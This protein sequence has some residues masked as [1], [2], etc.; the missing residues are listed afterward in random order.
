M[1]KKYIRKSHFYG[2]DK[3]RTSHHQPKSQAGVLSQLSGQKTPFC[4]WPTTVMGSV[5]A[6][7]M[8]VATSALADTPVLLAKKAPLS[9]ASPT[10]LTKVLPPYLPPFFRD[11]VQ[12]KP[13]L[14][15]HEVLFIDQGVSGYQGLLDSMA[16]DIEV[17]FLSP[18]QDGVAAIAEHL[19][20]KTD[21]RGI[22]IVSHG[23]P[24]RLYL[25]N[26][27]LS[28]EELAQRQHDLS[29]WSKALGLEG[30]V[31]LYGCD[32]ARGV[33]G[34]RF[35]NRLS[36]A[37]T[38]GISASSDP[39]GSSV[40]G[41]DWAFEYSRN[42]ETETIFTGAVSNRFHALL[43]PGKIIAGDG[44]GGGGGGGLGGI[45]GSKY[46]PGGFGGKGG[47]GAG[48]DDTLTGTD[49]ND[50]IFGDGN[51]GGGGGGGAG[52]NAYAGGAGYSGGLGGSGADV[53]NGGGGDDILFG[54]G[55]NGLYGENGTLNTG[56]TGGA[57]G[58]ETLDA[59]SGGEGGAPV[60]FDTVKYSGII[61]PTGTSGKA[62]FGGA[63][64]G[65]PGGSTSNSIYG[66][67]GDNGSTDPVVQDDTW[68]ADHAVTLAKIS[69][70]YYDGALGGN[71]DDEL[72]GGPGSDVLFGMGGANT[73]IFE[74]N[75]A[76]SG[77]DVD[78]I[79][80]WNDGSGN[81]IELRVDGDTFDSDQVDTVV[82]SQGR[83]LSD[84]FVTHKDDYRQ[85]TIVVKNLGRDLTSADF[86]IGSG[87][88]I[89][90][91]FPWPM[92][93]PAIISGGQKE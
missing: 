40:L 12:E 15:T 55:L 35:V 8:V 28:V 25:G 72:D 41:G 69:N 34:I 48:D 38:A 22:H 82:A 23:D 27:T 32:V 50:V 65:L 29:I 70:G 33:E 63:L 78:V 1:V 4:G 81:L 21:L 56:G 68:G 57:S 16:R 52:T 18:D 14:S 54:D 46:L 26:M 7:G 58:F 20:G 74:T 93:M 37:L 86:V 45:Y 90:P 51:G 62:G 76:T 24:G 11:L 10:Y 42:V 43:A 47:D 64:G 88:V 83:A 75:D 61:S 59:G 44:S 60:D 39:T 84:R 49:G 19:E 9:V 2:M 6:L 53:I 13:V 66:L 31:L 79:Y 17:V 87:A 36:H 77:H 5:L 92:F 80:G 67:S 85:V 89:T 91:S 30:D 71:G 73:F 3:Y